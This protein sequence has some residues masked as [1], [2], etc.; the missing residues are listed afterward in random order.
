MEALRFEA[1]CDEDMERAI[2]ARGRRALWMRKESWL[3]TWQIL[4]IICYN[5]T[6]KDERRRKL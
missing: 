3:P 2:R 6:P 5:F 1:A 4:K